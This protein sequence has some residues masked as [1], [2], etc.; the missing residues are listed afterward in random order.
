MTTKDTEVLIE[1]LKAIYVQLSRSSVRK[2]SDWHD[3]FRC[4]IAELSKSS[5]P[6]ASRNMRSHRS[7]SPN[8]GSRSLSA[9]SVCSAT[10]FQPPPPPPASLI[11]VRSLEEIDAAVTS[12]KLRVETFLNERGHDFFK[13]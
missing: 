12:L 1:E 8:N 7:D 6:D 13:R 2:L 10:S 3:L 5:E 11:T 4:T 9:Q